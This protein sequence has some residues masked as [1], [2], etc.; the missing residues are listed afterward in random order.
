[1]AVAVR[2]FEDEVTIRGG[3]GL[4]VLSGRKIPLSVGGFDIPT[5]YYENLLYWSWIC[6]WAYNGYDC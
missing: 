5:S 2:V 6:W 3:S 4:G 1:M